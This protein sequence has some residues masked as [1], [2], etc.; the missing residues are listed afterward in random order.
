MSVRRK[1]I[2]KV[3]FPFHFVFFLFALIGLWKTH[4]LWGFVL[5]AASVGMTAIVAWLVG[6]PEAGK[7][8]D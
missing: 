4:T 1:N 8:D 6:K 2:W 5:L 7:R 3:F